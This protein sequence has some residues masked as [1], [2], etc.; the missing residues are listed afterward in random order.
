MKTRSTRLER[1]LTEHFPWVMLNAQRYHEQYGTDLDD[2]LAAGRRAIVRA[3]R[4]YDT[5]KGTK[6]LTY[7]QWVIR[8]EMKRCVARESGF[9]TA[10]AQCWWLASKLDQRCSRFD[11]AGSPTDHPEHETAFSDTPL[12]D[13]FA[14][15]A[16]SPSD[17]A[18][19]ADLAAKVL[20]IVDTLHA[21]DRDVILRLFWRGQ[22][23][24]EV[25]ADLGISHQAV[26]FR[27]HRIKAKLRIRLKPIYEEA[28]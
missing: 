12:H 22:A 23:E 4:G 18:A 3:D 21:K 14:D 11:A 2:L 5:R 1:R 26:N 27:F 13:L 8:S 9:I 16:P 7:A 6:F 17:A 24:P 10:P 28:A 20:A 15:P 25:A 19:Q